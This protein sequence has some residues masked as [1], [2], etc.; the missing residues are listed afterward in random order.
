MDKLRSYLD[1]DSVTWWTGMAAI[2][3]GVLQAAGVN[4]P[5][6]GIMA[7]VLN[8]LNGGTFAASPAQLIV[9]GLG[10]IGIRAKLERAA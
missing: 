4:H 3:L 10:L 9:L 1:F 7:E 8:S 5:S 6:F 2:V